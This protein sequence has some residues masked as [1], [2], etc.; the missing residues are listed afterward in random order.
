MMPLSFAAVLGDDYPY[1]FR[2]QLVSIWYTRRYG[3]RPFSFFQFTLPGLVLALVGFLF[4][5]YI[6]SFVLTGLSYTEE[7]VKNSNVFFIPD[8]S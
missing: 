1:W 8:Y 2:N 3:T 7:F 6:T 5:F 4:V